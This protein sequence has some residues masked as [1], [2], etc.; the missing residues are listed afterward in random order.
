MITLREDFIV[1]V[2]LS[3]LLIKMPDAGALTKA[4]EHP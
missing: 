4:C 1:M 3:D 2:L